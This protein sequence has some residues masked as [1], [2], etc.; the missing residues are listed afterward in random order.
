MCKFKLFL[1]KWF[2]EVDN[3]NGVVSGIDK[4]VI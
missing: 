4:F 3:N 1:V 2:E